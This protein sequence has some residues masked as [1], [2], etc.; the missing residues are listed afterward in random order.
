LA[1]VFAE[2]TAD[3]VAE[4]RDRVDELVHDETTPVRRD[5][6]DTANTYKMVIL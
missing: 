6:D 3:G 4:A 5:V 1:N 2:G